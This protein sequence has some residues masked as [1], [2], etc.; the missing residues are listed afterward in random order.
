MGG[1]AALRPLLGRF[2]RR[3]LPRIRVPG[4]APPQG[5]MTYALCEP[6]L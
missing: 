3:P 5:Q 1:T 6:K 2:K 4:A